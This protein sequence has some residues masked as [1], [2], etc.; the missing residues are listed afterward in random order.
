MCQAIRFTIH[1]QSITVN[2][3]DP[4]P[5]VPILMR[6]GNLQIMPWGNPSE[7]H[8]F[9]PPGATIHIDELRMNKFR[10]H[11]PRSVS[12]SCNAYM[13][14]DEKNQH[15]WFELDGKSQQGLKAVT[16]TVIDKDRIYILMR[17]SELLDQEG[18]KEWPV[19]TFLGGYVHPKNRK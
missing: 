18:F 8:S 15:R 6:N 7:I 10:H 16:A 3:T 1:N 19:P 14:I 4:N 17:T 11:H 5:C 2:F 13:L 12:I 9:Y